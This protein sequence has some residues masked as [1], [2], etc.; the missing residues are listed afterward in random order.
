MA[1]SAIF[2]QRMTS[3][4]SSLSASWPAVAEN[5]K[6]GRMKSACAR[7]ESVVAERPLMLAGVER[8]QDDE[9]VLEDVVVKGAEELG[10][11]EG[12]E[13]PLPQQFVLVVR[14]LMGG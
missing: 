13:A 7:L 6:N 14:P 10:D 3:D 4:F 2:T 11:E 5:R 9:R 12:Q 1:I 8:E